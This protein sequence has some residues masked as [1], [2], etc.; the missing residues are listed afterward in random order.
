M[1]LCFS[2]FSLFL[3]FLFVRRVDL[4]RIYPA[5]FAA[6]S[7]ILTSILTLRAAALVIFFFSLSLHVHLQR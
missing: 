1:S 5:L 6:L 2:F 7:A 4:T 3:L